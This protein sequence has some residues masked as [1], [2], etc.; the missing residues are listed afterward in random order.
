MPY[1]LVRATVEDFAKFK[2]VFDEAATLRRAHGSKGVRVVRNV[3]KPNDVVLLAEYDD[4]GQARQLFQSQ[5]F[6]EATKRAG[7]SG[8][9]DVSFLDE[10]TGCRR[11]GSVL[12]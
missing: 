3:D 10:R 1:T 4:L 5:E 2:P 8:P 9:P 6:H 7:V 11:D 12:T